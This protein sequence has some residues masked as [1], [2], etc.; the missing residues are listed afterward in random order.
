MTRARGRASW[1]P[2]RTA[3][4]FGSCGRCFPTSLR[5]PASNPTARIG[6]GTELGADVSIGP[7]VVLGRSV[8]VGARNRL[9]QHVTLDDGVT[10]GEDTIIGPGAV[11]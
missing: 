3:R 11:C 2:I 4:S 5:C 10:V 1:W 7:F 6:A 9:A 8:R